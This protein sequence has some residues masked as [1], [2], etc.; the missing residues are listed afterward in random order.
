[1]KTVI[2]KNPIGNEINERFKNE[3]FKVV[4]D[5]GDRLLVQLICADMDKPWFIA[6]HFLYLKSDMKDENE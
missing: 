5:R 3:R 2:F 1:M 6:P 4:E